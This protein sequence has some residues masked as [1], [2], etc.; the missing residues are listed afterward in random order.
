MQVY[1][2]KFSDFF[3]GRLEGL[4]GFLVNGGGAFY[5]AFHSELFKA[6]ASLLCQPRPERLRLNG[7][8]KNACHAVL[9]FWVKVKRGVASDFGKAAGVG[10]QDRAAGNKGFQNR[11]SKAFQHGGKAKK[12]GVFV[13]GAQLPFVRKKASAPAAN[14]KRLQGVRLLLR[15]RRACAKQE[16]VVFYKKRR[17]ALGERNE[18]FVAPAAAGEQDVRLFHR[19]RKAL[20]PP[21]FP[22]YGV[23]DDINPGLVHKREKVKQVLFCVLGNGDYARGAFYGAGLCQRRFVRRRKGVWRDFMNEVVDGKDKRLVFGNGRNKVIAGMVYVIGGAAD[24]GLVGK[25]VQGAYKPAFSLELILYWKR[26]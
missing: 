24:G 3:G 17:E 11:K 15:E 21:L 25:A 10:K 4:Q 2:Y 19:E 13:D 6:L 14:S 26:L 8:L 18:V 9:A 22:L 23:K 5:H 16:K 12:Q 7:G 20:L 1:S